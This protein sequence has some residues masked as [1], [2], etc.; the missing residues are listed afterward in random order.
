MLNP[1]GNSQILTKRLDRDSSAEPVV[2]IRF[3]VDTPRFSPDGK[4][5]A[6]FSMDTGRP[7]IYVQ[8]WGAEGEKIPVTKDGGMFSVWAPDG[9]SLFFRSAG[10]FYAVDVSTSGAFSAGEKKILFEG[11]Y[12]TS[13]DISPDGETFLLV[14]DEHGTLPSELNVVLNWTDELKRIMAATR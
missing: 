1:Q 7:Q 14:R 10:K 6:Y 8:S 9:R 2:T 4:W 12:L 5:P 11:K 13:F 3:R